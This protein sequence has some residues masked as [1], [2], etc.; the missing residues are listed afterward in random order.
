MILR[1]KIHAVGTQFI[2][3]LDL[4]ALRNRPMNRAPTNKLAGFME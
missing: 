4:I 1:T 3:R 2:A